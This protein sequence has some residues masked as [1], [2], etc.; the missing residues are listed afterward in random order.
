MPTYT[1]R[2]ENCGHQFDKYQSFQDQPLKVCPECRKH[3]LHKVYRAAG[4]S[5]KGSGFYVT[6]K[7]GSGKHSSTKPAKAKENGTT[8][9]KAEAKPEKKT[10]T[11]SEK[12]APKP[13][14]ED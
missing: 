6:D 2:C 10:D 13:K 4:V 7:G 12:S 11:T 5:F 14:K 3:T 9:S 8:E 1:Y